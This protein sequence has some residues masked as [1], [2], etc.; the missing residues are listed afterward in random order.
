ML[1]ALGWANP[2]IATTMGITLPTLHKYY[3][4]ELGQRE[5]ARDM[6]EMR[7][8]E[9][10]LEMAESGNVGALREFGRLLD[11]NDRMEAER[12]MATKPAEEERSMERLGKKVIDAQRAIAADADLM[13][14][15]EREAKLNARH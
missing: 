11:R 12:T 9:M 7:R 1:V 2:R 8:M 13:A 15:L 5:A 14:E 3:F 6:L 10:A 4:Y